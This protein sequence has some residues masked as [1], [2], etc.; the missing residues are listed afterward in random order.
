MREGSSLIL[1]KHK[2]LC[3]GG[4]GGLGPGYPLYPH[5]DSGG[6]LSHLQKKPH[7]MLKRV[8]KSTRFGSKAPGVF[9][10]NVNENIHPV[11]VPTT[12]FVFLLSITST[13]HYHINI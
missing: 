6:N 10:S 5:P 8:H 7:I 4:G 11:G 13:R 1:K 12:I 2:N 3:S 9:P